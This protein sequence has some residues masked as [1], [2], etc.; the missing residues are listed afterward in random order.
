M[1]KGG[2]RDK[3]KTGI[4]YLAVGNQRG[5]GAILEGGG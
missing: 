2:E 3:G 1:A 4:Q 5:S